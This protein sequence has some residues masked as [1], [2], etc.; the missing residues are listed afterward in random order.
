MGVVIYFFDNERLYLAANYTMVN[1][2]PKNEEA[3]TIKDYRP[4][5]G[6]TTLYK[7]ISKVLTDRLAKVI[8]SIISPCQADFVPGKQIHNYILLTY[9]LLKGYSRKGGAPKCMM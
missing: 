7:I 3:K 8:R 1:L 5:A 6:C 2:I 9:E 4:I